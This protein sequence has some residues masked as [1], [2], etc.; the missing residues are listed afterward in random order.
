VKKE[1][2]S[3]VHVSYSKTGGA[4]QV[5]NRLV[6]GQLA[7]GN[8]SRF[9][10]FNE[11]SL[12]ERPLQHPLLTLRALADKYIVA[13]RNNPIMFSHYRK[14][15]VF[16]NAKLL[17]HK[18]SSSIFH[19]HWLS[20]VMSLEEVATLALNND[21]VWTVHDASVFSGGCHNLQGCLNISRNCTKCPQV[22]RP[23]QS[24][25]ERLQRKK[26]ELGMD[27]R[28]KIV[29]PSSKVLTEFKSSGLFPN[30]TFSVIPN[31][32]DPVFRL[33]LDRPL[34]RKKLGIDNNERVLLF[35]AQNLSDQ[36]K[37]I[38]LLDAAVQLLEKQ[39]QKNYRILAIGNNPPKEMQG[40]PHILF[41]E[42]KYGLELAELYSVADL[43]FN[44][45]FGESFS[46]TI[47]EAATIG[48]PSVVA[49]NNP[50]T[51]FLNTFAGILCHL[52]GPEI[53][54]VVSRFFELTPEEKERMRSAL[55]IES[56]VFQIDSIIKKYDK[57]YGI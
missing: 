27:M 7:R 9:V 20:G 24:D 11:L 14:S 18:Q 29:C 23:F 17:T 54:S 8:D 10:F 33:V 6:S 55:L 39:S 43:C 41:V 50:I 45:S 56:E 40:K 19:L 13:K 30:S 57:V 38:H 31:P 1:K 2:T 44:L 21:V 49:S 34:S 53:A 48:I 22:N 3:I 35:V 52:D 42:P 25:I 36:N 5:A 26:L 12:H 32:V 15:N 37:N 51:E 28:L 4:G 16:T 47:A 46:L